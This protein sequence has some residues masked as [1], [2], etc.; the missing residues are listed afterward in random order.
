MTFSILLHLGAL[1][2]LFSIDIDLLCLKL[3]QQAYIFFVQ[4]VNDCEGIF[5]YLIT[6]HYHLLILKCHYFFFT[7]SAGTVA[8][9]SL[10]DIS[11]FFTASDCIDDTD[12][13]N[14][15]FILGLLPT[16]STCNPTLRLPRGHNIYMYNNIKESFY[17]ALNGNGGFGTL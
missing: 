9:C 7:F 8:D 11:I 1:L 16:S 3:E 13:A 17:L 12:S 6:I 14:L 2:A 10:Q 4:F 5:Y 15:E